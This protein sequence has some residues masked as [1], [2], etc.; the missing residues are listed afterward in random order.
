[1]ILSPGELSFFFKDRTRSLA[2]AVIPTLTP[3][4]FTTQR[5]YSSLSLS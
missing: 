5:T 4:L 1:M 2:P 3:P